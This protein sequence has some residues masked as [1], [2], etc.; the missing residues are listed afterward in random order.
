MEYFNQAIEDAY[1]ENKLLL[2]IYADLQDQNSGEFLHDIFEDIDTQD[3]L[4]E[5]YLVFGVDHGT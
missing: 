4:T 2:L 1:D 3:L 5:N